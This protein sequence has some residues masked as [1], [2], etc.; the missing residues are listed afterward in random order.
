MARSVR[1]D[2]A[3]S[4]P[5]PAPLRAAAPPAGLAARFAAFVAERHPFAL[6]S[7]VAAFG[8]VCR[9]EPERD[10]P[11]IEALRSPL[12]EAL[13]R[14][15]EPV[16]TEGLPDATPDVTVAERLEQARRELLD[17]CD[18]FLSRPLLQT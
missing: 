8:T 17:D 7:V 10:R 14:H 15:L 11:A 2:P 6:A 13:R 12:A 16:A 5:K 3:A 4:P 9:R 1:S 18:G